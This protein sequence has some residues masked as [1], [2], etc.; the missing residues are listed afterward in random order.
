MTFVNNSGPYT[1]KTLNT[2]IFFSTFK[3]TIFNLYLAALFDIAYK[4]LGPKQNSHLFFVLLDL[5][6]EIQNLYLYI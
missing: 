3:K 6:F 5:M 1:H 4:D 2:Q